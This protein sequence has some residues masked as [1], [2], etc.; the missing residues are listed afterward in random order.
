MQ[1]VNTQEV[2]QAVKLHMHAGHSLVFLLA[3]WSCQ[4]RQADERIHSPFKTVQLLLQ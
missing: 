3:H 4:A 2:N 1:H